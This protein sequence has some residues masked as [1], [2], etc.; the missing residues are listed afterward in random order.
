MPWPINCS[1]PIPQTHNTRGFSSSNPARAP[2]PADIIGHLLLLPRSANRSSSAAPATSQSGS[3]CGRGVG[4]DVSAAA[5]AGVRP[6]RHP[7]PPPPPL[8]CCHNRQTPILRAC[9]PIR[10]GHKTA[11]RYFYIS[12]G[13]RIKCQCFRKQATTCPGNGAVS[14]IYS[15]GR[16]MTEMS[17]V[18]VSVMACFIDGPDVCG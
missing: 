1:A 7:P 3:A 5:D 17:F 11:G 2:L 8:P 18:A 6:P 14:R 9:L 15:T 16:Q 13:C 12:A 4:A 10:P